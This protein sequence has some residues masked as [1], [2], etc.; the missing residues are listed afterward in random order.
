MLKNI[1]AALFDLDGTL[2][3][4][5][6]LWKDVDIKYLSS[7]GID[8]PKN[9]QKEIEGYSMKETAR[10][11][12]DR[13]GIEDSLEEMMAEWNEMARVEYESK[14]PLK[15][16]CKNFLEKLRK[17]NVKT[18][19]VTSNSREL[20]EAVY[21]NHPFSD[22]IDLVV[23]ANEVEHG[24]PAPD[25]YLKA[26]E[27]L[28]IDPTDCLVFEDIIAG[29]QAGKN[30]GM[31]V[32]TIYDDYSAEVDEEKRELADYYVKDYFELV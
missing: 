9:L 23:T 30:A 3:D 10:Y 28:G 24:K 4:S 1:K 13:F 16:G 8:M 20:V 32:C 2:V 18:A 12:K 26:A 25:V 22:F 27:K 29:I 15:P 7:R 5:M 31:K 19:I 6:G 14:V 11:F 21:K 17:R